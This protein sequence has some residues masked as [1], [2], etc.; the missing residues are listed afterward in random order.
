MRTKTRMKAGILLFLLNMYGVLNTF[1][2]VVL[3]LVYDVENTGVDCTK[4]PL[5]TFE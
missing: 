5:P 3:P 2:Q 4:P 1:G